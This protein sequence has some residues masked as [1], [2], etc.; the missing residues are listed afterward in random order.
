MSMLKDMAKRFGDGV[1]RRGSDVDQNV[2][3]VPT[4]ILTL[5]RATGVGG[6]PLGRVVEV[7]G[8]EGSSKS[9]LCLHVATEAQKMGL[10]VA[11]IDAEHALD[12]NYA[13]NIGV[14]PGKLLISQPDC[15]EQALDVVESLCLSG[16]VGVVVVDSVA[17][18]TPKAEIEGDMGDAH[19]GR[20][21]R[22]MSQALRKLVGAAHTHACLLLFVNQTRTKIGVTFGNPETTTG[23][24]AL[25]FYASM[26]IQTR[27]IEA[28][29]VDGGHIGMRV[30]ARVLKNKLAPPWQAAEYDVIYGRGADLV[31][32]VLDLALAQDLVTLRGS[33]YYL[34]E[35]KLGNGKQ[36]VVDAL[37]GDAA[38]LGRL[39]QAVGA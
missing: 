27:F 33:N 24:Q 31:G 29:K 3:V 5:D 2:P 12:I 28:I 15:G 25:K 36:R 35:E 17:A 9:T 30:C 23:G 18:L 19:V 22:L 7:Y 4:G 13:R 1:V 38:M 14:D 10:G 8:H 11:Y 32:S 6:L 39:R 20:H 16:E 34:G 26:R 21:A 37:R